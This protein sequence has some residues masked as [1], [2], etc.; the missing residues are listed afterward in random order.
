MVLVDE[1]L[2][3][4]LGLFSFAYEVVTADEP[5]KLVEDVG[6]DDGDDDVVVVVFL[7]VLG[8]SVT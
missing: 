7:D 4:S 6:I 3:E 5:G 8:G 1:E 2:V